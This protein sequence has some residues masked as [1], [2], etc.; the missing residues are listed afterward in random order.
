MV[1]TDESINRG[2]TTL[3]PQL[4]EL[5]RRIPLTSIPMGPVDL[6]DPVIQPAPDVLARNLQVR[7]QPGRPLTRTV[8][9][10]PAPRDVP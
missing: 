9:V 10:S 8:P 4:A 3:F 1:V 7:F 5:F 6:Q 2:R